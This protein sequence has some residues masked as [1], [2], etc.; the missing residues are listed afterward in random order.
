MTDRNA[1][2]AHPIHPLI[3][4]RHSP[5]AYTEAPVT[6]EQLASILEAGRWAASCFNE[7]PWNFVVARRDADP[8][9]FAT[10]LG[11]L[12]AFNQVWA[13]DASALVITVARK[14]FTGNG[15]PNAVALYD[16]GQAAANMVLQAASM[17]L[18]SR[19]MRGFDVERARV[20]LGVP[21]DND[22]VSA[23]AFGVP[24]DAAKILPPDV[25]AKEGLPR[26]RK[27][28]GEFSHVGKFGVSFAG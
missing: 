21:A 19:Q 4:G 11:L 15:N 27:P 18:A 14:V 23:I 17:G 12:G 8:E 5:R 28:I 13:K 25:A 2:T 1:P 26:V 10:L 16:V 20:E 7:Q 9:A 22:P 24:G 3:A 6:A